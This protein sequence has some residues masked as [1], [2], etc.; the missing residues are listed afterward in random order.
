MSRMAEMQGEIEINEMRAPC[1]IDCLDDLVEDS[2]NSNLWR[3]TVFGFQA[4]SNCP[5]LE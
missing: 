3:P 5:G 2:C 4:Q 1:K